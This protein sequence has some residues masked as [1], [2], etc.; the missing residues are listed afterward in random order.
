[1]DSVA[2]SGRLH[3]QGRS[4]SEKSDPQTTDGQGGLVIIKDG[5]ILEVSEWAA[6]PAVRPTKTCLWWVCTPWDCRLKSLP[7][8]YS[9]WNFGL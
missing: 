4:T 6:I 8:W 2:D 9:V 7:M 3:S 1:M 5:V